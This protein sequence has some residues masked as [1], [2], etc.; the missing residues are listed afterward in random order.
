MLCA[1][2]YHFVHHKKPEKHQWRSNTFI[3]VV[4]SLHCKINT[5]P[6]VFMFFELCKWYQIVQSVSSIVLGFDF[7]GML[8]QWMQFYYPTQIS[9]ISVHY[10][11]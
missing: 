8:I 2:C 5:S 1:I 11:I 4:C 7:L 3:K 6:C 9:T 10:P